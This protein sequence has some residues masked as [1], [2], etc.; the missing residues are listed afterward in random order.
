[1][2]TFRDIAEEALFFRR[3]QISKYTH[4][5]SIT[6]QMA[7]AS[8]VGES[9]ALEPILQIMEDADFHITHLTGSVTD[10][11]DVDGRRRVAE[12]DFAMVFPMA[13]TQQRG[14][15]GIYFKFQDVETNR[16]LQVCRPSNNAVISAA[17][18]LSP[19]DQTFM[20]F[21]DVFMPGY[22]YNWGKPVKFEYTLMRNSRLKVLLRNRQRVPGIGGT[23]SRVSMAFIGNRYAA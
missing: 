16:D 17:Q 20:S 7:T 21:N 22:G 12:T 5:Y 18:F 8:G 9:V 4:I 2:Q 13:G 6:L 1:M 14:E 23:Y 3:T 15:R 19:W 10:L 11:T